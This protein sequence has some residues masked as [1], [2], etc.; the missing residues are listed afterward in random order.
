M[1]TISFFI[2]QGRPS[3][4][5]NRLHDSSATILDVTMMLMSSVSFFIKQKR[6]AF[7]SDS[8]H[9]VSA[10]ILL[11]GCWCQL[12]LFS[13]SERGLLF[14]LI[15]CIFLSP[16]QVLCKCQCNYLFLYTA[17]IWNGFAADCFPWAY[18]LTDFKTLSLELTN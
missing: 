11:Q 12:F 5:S 3:F 17:R 6:S 7:Y 15:D 2:Q 10:T 18:D 1:P 4:Y 9:E 13:Q 16:S 14:M 8:L